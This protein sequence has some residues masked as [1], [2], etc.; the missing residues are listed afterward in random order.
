LQQ[1]S[2]AQKKTYTYPFL[3][4]FAI[5]AKEELKIING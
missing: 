5:F 2:I 3:Q 1:F 4:K